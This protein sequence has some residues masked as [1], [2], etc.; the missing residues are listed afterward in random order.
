MPAYH[1][2]KFLS[3]AKAGKKRYTYLISYKLIIFDRGLPVGLKEKGTG[4]AMP[5]HFTGREKRKHSRKKV[6]IIA[7]LKMGIYLNGRG[8]ARDISKS[9]M[10]LVAPNIFKLIK[11]AQMSDYIGANIKIMFPSQSLTV[12]GTLV[13]I[14][15]AKGEGAV[16][17]TGTTDDEAWAK[18]CSE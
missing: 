8:Y 17:I 7:L 6:K 4:A 11:P 15:P 14:N 10:C 18:L 5:T 16:S 12:N 3:L 9:G 2:V 13:R 1:G